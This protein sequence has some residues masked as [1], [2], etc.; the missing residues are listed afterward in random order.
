MGEGYPHAYTIRLSLLSFC[1][2]AEDADLAHYFSQTL[3]AKWSTGNFPSYAAHVMEGSGLC[4]LSIVTPRPTTLSALDGPRHTIS[5]WPINTFF[6]A[7]KGLRYFTNYFFPGNVASCS[8]CVFLE[9]IGV[10][11]MCSSAYLRDAILPSFL[12]VDHTLG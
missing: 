10:R 8:S 4:I 6:H 9:Y 11:S 3:R 5:H 2:L 7:A 12:I 1:Y